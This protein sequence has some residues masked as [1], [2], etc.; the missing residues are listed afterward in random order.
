MLLFNII[1]ILALLGFIGSGLK[2]GLI[3]A[4][5]RIVGA[6]VGFV[7]AKT[8][9]IEA[10]VILSP[11]LPSNWAR[12]FAFLIIFILATRV[13]GWIFKALD[14]TFNFIAVIPFLKSI[15]HALGGFLG[16]LEGM[17]VIGGLIWF[18]KTFNVIPSALT[19][20][21]GS[22]MASWIY[23]AFTKVLGLLL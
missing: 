16:F 1:L 5:G 21:N 13:M 6:V 15:N 19:Y 8:F 22:F 12:I 20:I 4:L 3:Y 23:G 7:I 10:S 18:F 17:I 14:K 2:D 11:F 9:Y